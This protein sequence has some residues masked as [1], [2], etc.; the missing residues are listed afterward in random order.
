[1]RRAFGARIRVLLENRET[2]L[3]VCRRQAYETLQ[4][5]GSC[6]MVLFGVMVRFP[7]AGACGQADHH[8]DRGR[9]RGGSRACKPSPTSRIAQKKLAM[10]QDF[11]QKFCGEPGKPWRTGTGRFRRPYQA[12]GDLPKALD[13]G[14]KALAGLAAQPRHP[15]VAE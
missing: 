2:S 14:D 8:C 11:V 5:V 13:Y 4:R 9:H 6:W 7:F 3:F 12:T 15:R 1:V 10:Y